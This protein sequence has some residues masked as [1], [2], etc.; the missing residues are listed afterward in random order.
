MSGTRSEPEP[1]R[2]AQLAYRRP[3]QGHH[4]RHLHGA[5]GV[6]R[7]ILVAEVGGA[8][9]QVVIGHGDRPLVTAGETAPAGATGVA[10]RPPVGGAGAERRGAGRQEKPEGMSHGKLRSSDICAVG[11]RSA[12]D[13]RPP[14][15]CGGCCRCS[16]S[17]RCRKPAAPGPGAVVAAEAPED[18]AVGVGVPAV[19]GVA[20]VEV[21]QDRQRVR[22]RGGPLE[23]L[24][25]PQ[26]PQVVVDAPLRRELRLGGVPQL[27]LGRAGVEA[28]RE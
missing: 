20:V 11:A 8:G 9:P 26:H 27:V 2:R 24:L 28:C 12:P 14:G 3:E 4:H 10:A 25:A 17:G 7:L 21:D 15:T 16:C 19:Q 6:E 18:A 13:S 5:G 1:A 22:G 23:D